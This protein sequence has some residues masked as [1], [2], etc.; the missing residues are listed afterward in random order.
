MKK[1]YVLEIHKF[2]YYPQPE[3]VKSNHIGYMNKKFNTK[4]EAGDY[5]D[6]FNPHMRKLNAHKNWCSDCDPN[7]FLMYIVKEQF[8][9]YLKIPSFEDTA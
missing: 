8:Y 4:Q 2:N 6:K 1:T 5:Y 9:E 7:T 3:N